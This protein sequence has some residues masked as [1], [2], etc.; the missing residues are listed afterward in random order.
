PRRARQALRMGSRR[1]QPED[2]PSQVRPPFDA[3]WEDRRLPPG[4][5]PAARAGVQVP[6]VQ[7]GR[8]AGSTPLPNRPAPTARAPGGS[9]LVAVAIGGLI[10]GIALASGRGDPGAPS[11]D[12]ARGNGLPA[13]GGDR[14]PHDPRRDD[15]L[16]KAVRRAQAGDLDR[17]RDELA[18]TLERDP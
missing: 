11:S 13:V 9:I 3:V 2:G 16:R 17:A 10:A 12:P 6:D 14:R 15:K 5:R 1:L 8:V 7:P 18:K 4:A